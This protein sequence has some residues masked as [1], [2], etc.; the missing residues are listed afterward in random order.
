MQVFHF[1]HVFKRTIV[2]KISEIKGFNEKRPE[3]SF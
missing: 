1:N 3:E 2:G